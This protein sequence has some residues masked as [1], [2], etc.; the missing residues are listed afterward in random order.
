MKHYLPSFPPCGD[1]FLGKLG[2]F[3]TDLDV[4]SS[5]WTYLVENLGYEDELINT[6][7]CYPD[8][9][10][11]FRQLMVQIATSA[12]INVSQI[13]LFDLNLDLNH[14]PSWDYAIWTMPVVLA[15]LLSD[16]E[17]EG[18]WPM[19]ALKPERPELQGN[20][21]LTAMVLNKSSGEVLGAP[22]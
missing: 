8:K 16:G 15:E 11:E 2:Q 12:K 7:L 3:R 9:P 1:A 20:R 14:H 21:R 5:A 4:W 22:V 19:L 13:G 17:G 18:N 6:L 10:M